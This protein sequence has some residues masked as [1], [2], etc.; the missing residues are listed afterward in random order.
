MSSSTTGLRLDLT[1]DHGQLVQAT[2]RG[3]GV[4]GDEIT[5][6]VRTIRSVPLTLKGDYPDHFHIRGEIYHPQGRVQEDE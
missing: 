1:Y 4:Q 3:D 2:T 5:A 6:N